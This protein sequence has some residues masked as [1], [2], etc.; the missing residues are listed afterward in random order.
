MSITTA[1]WDIDD[2]KRCHCR[3]YRVKSWFI[4]NKISNNALIAGASFVADEIHDLGDDIV[5]D[6]DDAVVFV[7]KK[8]DSTDIDVFDDDLDVFATGK[9][10]CSERHHNAAE[11]SDGTIDTAYNNGFC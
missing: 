9:T 10:N 2:S 11:K 8:F 1:V 4:G 6:D 5:V 7:S 3:R